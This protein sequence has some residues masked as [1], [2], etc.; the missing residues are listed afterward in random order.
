MIDRKK[1]VRF[2]QLSCLIIGI[3]IVFFTY[4]DNKGKNK[5]I[6]VSKETEAEVKKQAADQSQSKD[7]FSNIEYSGLDLA[8]N[9]YLLRAKEASTTKEMPHLVNMSSVEAIFY[10][11]DNAILKV[12]S[13]KGK[14][15]NKTLD[16]LFRENVKGFY[17]GSELYAEKAEYSNS[18]SFLTITEKVKIKDIKGT[19]FADKLL[20]DIKKQTLNIASF[21]DKKISTNVKLK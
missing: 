11:K 16:M 1:K 18:K 9:R 19:M 6:I 20:F 5:N 17:E 7:V 13:K 4:V 3:L 10:F 8:G 15:N 21:N 12:W 14:Y 2:I